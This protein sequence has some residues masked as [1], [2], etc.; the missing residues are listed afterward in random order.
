MTSIFSVVSQI[1]KEETV[2]YIGYIE[3]AT[4]IGMSIGAPLG[5]FLNAYL[6][7]EK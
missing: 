3:S 7:F 5:S 1:Y 6:G 2:L 4:T